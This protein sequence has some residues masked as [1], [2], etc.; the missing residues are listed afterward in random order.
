MSSIELIGSPI[1]GRSIS[2]VFP[3][4]D[5]IAESDAWM[6][7]FVASPAARPRGFLPLAPD[8]SF[9]G[10]E[11]SDEDGLSAHSRGR[12]LSGRMG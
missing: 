11:P 4:G 1:P 2:R 7:R 9:D 6:Q 5:T 3:G 8:R 10:A 12:R